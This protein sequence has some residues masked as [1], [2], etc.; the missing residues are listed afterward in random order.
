VLHNKFCHEQP[1]ASFTAEF[2]PKVGYLHLRP[3][4]RAEFGIREMLSSIEDLF[5]SDPRDTST[6]NS[7]LRQSTLQVLP[8]LRGRIHATHS[9]VFCRPEVGFWRSLLDGHSFP[10]LRV[11][12]MDHEPLT[13]DELHLREPQLRSTVP[14][15]PRDVEGLKRLLFFNVSN[16]PELNDSVLIATL[17]WTVTLKALRLFRNRALTY[18]G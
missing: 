5:S 7:G 14:I 3:L 8:R 17:P 6:S 9:S 2:F 11:L 13:E 18:A 15:E 1:M 12:S 4:N 16:C 10:E